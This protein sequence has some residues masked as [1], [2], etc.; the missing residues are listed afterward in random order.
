MRDGG[1][2]DAD[3][4]V[5]GGKVWLPLAAVY[6]PVTF[7][8]V[9]N[10][11]VI[12]LSTS[13]VDVPGHVGSG[14]SRQDPRWRKP[15]VTYIYRWSFGGCVERA[16]NAFDVWKS[17][18]R[19]QVMFARVR[20]L[21]RELHHELL[22]FCLLLRPNQVGESL[23]SIQLPQ[24]C[25]LILNVR[26]SLGQLLRSSDWIPEDWKNKPWGYTSVCLAVGVE[27]RP[28][29]LKLLAAILTLE[30]GI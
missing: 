2:D 27:T 23:L 6:Q 28:E 19:G 5:D 11:L 17:R 22:V 21:F 4:F 29:N 12:R 30:I 13:E 15:L 20:D 3:F 14:D 10:A 25:V 8:C 18:E 9:P 1:R 24:V 26:D 7:P 16:L